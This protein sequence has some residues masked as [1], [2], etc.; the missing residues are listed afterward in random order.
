[1]SEVNL[2]QL[3]TM[4]SG[5]RWNEDYADKKSDVA[6]FNDHKPEE[7]TGHDC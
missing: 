3:L 6:L 5:V 1:M 7:G 4:T 2:R